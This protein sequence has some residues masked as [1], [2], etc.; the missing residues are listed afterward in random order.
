M[1]SCVYENSLVNF[2]NCTEEANNH[3]YHKKEKP[4]SYPQWKGGASLSF[5]Y[6]ARIDSVSWW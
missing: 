6:T 4:P 3:G 1:P 2:K 5:T